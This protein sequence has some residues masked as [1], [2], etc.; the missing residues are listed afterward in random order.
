MKVLQLLLDPSSEIEAAKLMEA[1][2]FV[3]W[4][5]NML[6]STFNY[7]SYVTLGPLDIIAA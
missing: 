5:K 3:Q 6:T 4:Y 1:S 7:A 2:E